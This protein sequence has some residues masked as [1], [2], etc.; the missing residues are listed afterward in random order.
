VPS[1]KGE[2]IIVVHAGGRVGF[3]SRAL[4]IYKSSQKTGDYHNEINNKTYSRSL[5]K[6]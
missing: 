1:P 3:I 2:T 4:L 6:F 5:K